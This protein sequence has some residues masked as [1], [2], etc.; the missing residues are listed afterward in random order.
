MS[1]VICLGEAVVD[2]LAEPPG[3]RLT[4]AGG[5][6]PSFG[7]SQANVAIGAARLGAPTV[8][9]GCAGTDPWGVWLRERLASEGVDV[10]LYDLRAEVATTMAFVTLDRAGEPEFS[11]Y[12][13]A[14]DG[15]LA[16]R[17]TR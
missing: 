9:A 1:R 2:F 14:E 4:E 10:S 3:G 5:F 16:G 7:G 17:E 15:M 13:G 12:G 6:V 8:L 11:I